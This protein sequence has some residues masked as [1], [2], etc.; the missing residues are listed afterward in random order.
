MQE[1]TPVTNELSEKN[2]PYKVY[3]HRGPIHSLEQAA[4]ERGQF[5]DQVVRS[6]VFRL[7]KGEYLMVLIAGPNQISWSV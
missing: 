5:P 6:I 7:S 2:I 4:Q 1:S 3:Q